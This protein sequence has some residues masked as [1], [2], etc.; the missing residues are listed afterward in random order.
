M[1]CSVAVTVWVLQSKAC[2]QFLMEKGID[3]G[4]LW[5]RLSIRNAVSAFR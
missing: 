5:V 4:M 3:V 2:W 1:L